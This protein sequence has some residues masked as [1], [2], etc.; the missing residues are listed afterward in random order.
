LS[1]DLEDTKN[2]FFLEFANFVIEPYSDH[3]YIGDE[4]KYSDI[5]NIYEL[6]LIYQMIQ[7]KRAKATYVEKISD[8]R[9]EEE[10]FNNTRKKMIDF[11]K[12]FEKREN[13]ILSD[14]EENEFIIKLNN[15]EYISPNTEKQSNSVN[16]YTFFSMMIIAKI[17]K[18]RA[19]RLIS[20]I[21]E[22][23]KK[24]KTLND[25]EINK[26]HEHDSEIYLVD[27]LFL[28]KSANYFFYIHNKLLEDE[29]KYTYKNIYNKIKNKLIEYTRYKK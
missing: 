15:L 28:K 8:K 26:L 17:G 3:I 11:I 9:K 24:Y 16:K 20:C 25:N 21:E 29:N 6:L 4:I 2:S 27:K 5:K 18:E 12:K 7:M 13:G 10:S 19:T 14:I 1:N 22:C 23:N